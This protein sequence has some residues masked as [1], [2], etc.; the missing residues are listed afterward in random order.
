M[1]LIFI[2]WRRIC[3]VIGVALASLLLVGVFFYI[4]HAQPLLVVQASTV[5]YLII[6]PASAE[7]GVK[8]P[9]LEVHIANNGL[10]LLRGATVIS[11]SFGVIQ[12]SMKWGF[13]DFVWRVQTTSGTKFF[14][15][16]G[17][18]E[19]EDDIAI[20]DIVTVTGILISS[21]EEPTIVAQFMS[22]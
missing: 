1:S 17:E 22:E 6:S 11:N 13:A 9:M 4:A 10:M 14:T 16:K 21:G 7:R 8:I 18:K 5:K 12:V 19:T 3:I 15:S 20:G 2:H